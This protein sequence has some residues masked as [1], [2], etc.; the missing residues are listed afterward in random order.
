MSRI[1]VVEDSSTQALQIQFLLEDAGF[2]VEVARN[3]VEGLDAIGRCAPDAVLTDMDMPEM[4]GLELVEAV[5]R[6]HP[7]VPILLMTAMGSEDIAAQALQKGAASYVPKK[8]LAR[9]IVQTLRTVLD[10]ARASQHEHRVLECLTNTEFH[11]QLDNDPTLIPLLIGHLREHIARMRFCDET[12]LIRVNVALNEALHNAIFHGNLDVGSDLRQED[13][14][15]FYDLAE[16]RR[17]QSPYRERRVEMIVKVGRTE[18]VYVVRDEGKGFDASK[19]PDPNDPANLDRIGGRGL[20]LI[21]TFMD[22]VS[23]NRR[24]NEVTLIKRRR[25]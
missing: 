17:K 23:H 16:R 7:T 13:E 12:E 11:F 22:S 25:C 6:D 18:A 1:L 19:L 15:A 5:R 9:D 3:G 21:R 14:R 2:E 8:N 24:G 10:M 20:L 4:N